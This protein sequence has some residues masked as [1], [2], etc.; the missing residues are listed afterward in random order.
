MRKKDV[1]TGREVGRNPGSKHGW[2]ALSVWASPQEDATIKLI[3]IRTGKTVHD[4]FRPYV[5]KLI[6]EGLIFK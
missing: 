1:P 5:K 4:L 6:K 2:I 3:A